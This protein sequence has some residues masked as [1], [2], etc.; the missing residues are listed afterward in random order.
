MSMVKSYCTI[1]FNDLKK[2]KS[3]YHDNI[4]IPTCWCNNNMLL[5]A[6]VTKRGVTWD[7]K[8][9]FDYKRSDAQQTKVIWKK[10]KMIVTTEGGNTA[11][12]F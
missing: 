7:M 11:N 5:A 10:C 9:W 1:F 8:K 3:S 12:S 2:E 4:N 6:T